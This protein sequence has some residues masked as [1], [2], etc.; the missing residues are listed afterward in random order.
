MSW[1]LSL[2]GQM[3]VIFVH[4]NL[5]VAAMEAKARAVL[6]TCPHSLMIILQVMLLTPFCK[7]IVDFAFCALLYYS[8]IIAKIPSHLFSNSIEL[9]I[10]LGRKVC[11]PSSQHLLAL[12]NIRR[13]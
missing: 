13:K 5:L 6:T 2:L 3:N 1:F 9:V 11:I 8:A 10:T 7:Q 4:Q 12:F